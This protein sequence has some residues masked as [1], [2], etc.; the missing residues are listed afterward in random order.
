IVDFLKMAGPLALAQ[1]ITLVV[2]PLQ[3]GDTNIINTVPEALEYVQAANSPAVRLLVDSYHFWTEKET[4]QSVQDAAAYLG[5]VHVADLA[6]RA[7]P[8]E[9]GPAAAAMY[10]E[11]FSVLKRGGYKGYISVEAGTDFSP[12]ASRVA[13]FLREQWE[14]A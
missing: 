1:G 5:H 4:L 10:R 9:S 2:E 13:A 8:G 12:A 7:A 14:Q 6:N 11:F 3:R